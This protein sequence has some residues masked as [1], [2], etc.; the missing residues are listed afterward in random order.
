MAFNRAFGPYGWSYWCLLICNGLTPQ[1]LW[2]KWVRQ[3][4]VPLFI[5][6]IIVNIGMWLERYVIVITSLTRDFIPAAWGTYH[7]TWNDWGIFLG[8]LGFFT[9]CMCLFVRFL[10]MIAF[11]EV[12][13]TRH[14]MTHGKH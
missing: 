6:S 7:G 10:P 1:T 4:P 13:V 9:F 2:F 14:E 12:R 11:Y 3:N 5:V 8:T